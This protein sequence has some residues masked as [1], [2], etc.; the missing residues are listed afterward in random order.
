MNVYFLITMFI[1]IY[2]NCKMHKKLLA[3]INHS[4]VR[5]FYFRTDIVNLMRSELM[6]KILRFGKLTLFEMQTVVL[7]FVYAHHFYSK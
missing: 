6:C 7:A 2:I 3:I 5:V 4:T 1:L